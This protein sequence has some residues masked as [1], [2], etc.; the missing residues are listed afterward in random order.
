MTKTN[1]RQER[2]LGLFRVVVCVDHSK[3]LQGLSPA[4]CRNIQPD[5]L[6]NRSILPKPKAQIATTLSS[7]M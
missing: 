5:E 6:H 4:W 1:E 7:Q 3:C 2:G